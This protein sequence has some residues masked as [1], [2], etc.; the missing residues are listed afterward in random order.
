MKIRAFAHSPNSGILTLQTNICHHYILPAV[1]TN[2]LPMERARYMN[3]IYSNI[4]FCL[5]T[6]CMVTKKLLL[7]CRSFWSPTMRVA[8]ILSILHWHLIAEAPAL[9]AS[10]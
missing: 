5:V 2:T 10:Q 8:G 4:Q 1:P 9:S 7:G 3:R 6:Y